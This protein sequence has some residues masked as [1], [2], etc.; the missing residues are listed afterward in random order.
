MPDANGN[1]GEVTIYVLDMQVDANH[2]G[3]MDNRDLTSVNN[4]MVFWVN[5]DVD[6]WHTVDVTDSEQDSLQINDSSLASWQQVPDCQYQ[7][8]LGQYAIP[9]TRDLED[10]ARLWIPGLTNL[11]HVL[12]TGD[13]ITL[14][15]RNNTGAGIRIFG[16]A[17]ADGG[18]N[19][20]FDGTT[21]SNQV[22]TAWYPCYGY[23]T[24][25][26][27]LVISAAA[28][29]QLNGLPPSDNFIFCGTSSGNDELVLQVTNQYGGVLGEA[30]VFLNLQD[31][32]QMYE[33]WSVGE[34]PTQLPS[35]IATNCGDQ[36]VASFT[37]PY[38]PT[39]DSTTP[40]ILHVHG[41]NMKTW[42][43]DRYA[44]TMFKR[45]YWQGYQGRFGS[46]R[47]P[48]ASGFVP[49]LDSSAVFFS[50]I[51]DT[52]WQSAI[53]LK[54]LLTRLN[55]LYPGQVELS[56]HSMGNIVVGETLRQA[57]TPLVQTYTAFQGNVPA[58]A[59]DP[60]TP[61][62]SLGS[63]DV[64][65]PNVYAHYWNATNSQYF[66]GVVGAASY[67]NF[68]NTNDFVLNHWLDY[69]PAKPVTSLNYNYSSTRGYYTNH[70]L[71]DPNPFILTFPAKTYEIFAFCQQA[72][73]NCIGEQP[74]VG[75]QF[76]FRSIPQ[77]VDLRL[78]PY[79][80]GNEHKYHSGQFRSDN[81]SR[82][83]FW[84]QVLVQMGL[85]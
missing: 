19:Y 44:E 62:V 30:S 52:A 42:E 20:L 82:A 65:E 10:Y 66:S 60:N 84:N 85:K 17:D 67:V 43:K 63:S 6:R 4:P 16:A 53:G 5:N 77:Q 29:Q 45:L 3:V 55:T 75:G 1:Y 40:Y 18:T 27:P 81:M 57:A 64:G 50:E 73:C 38:D 69:Q 41:S 15:W 47:W 74:S 78:A 33:R 9:C 31:I 72:K 68:F 22:D 21:A 71:N 28:W 61:T 36:G 23:V 59:Y 2:D 54:N 70:Y 11:M 13:G 56:A 79:N 32:K 49:V 39:L 14:Q 24:S 37:Y 46:F 35:N 12:R 51:E 7:N 48:T 76:T 34:D 26:Q 83:V 25:N 8:A 80:F 58:H